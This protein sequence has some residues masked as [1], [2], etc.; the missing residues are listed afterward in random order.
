[1]TGC[2]PQHGMAV[3]EET[4]GSTASVLLSWS[5]LPMR[6]PS[7][8]AG[9]WRRHGFHFEEAIVTGCGWPLRVNVDQE[10]A[11]NPAVASVK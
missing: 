9:S 11:M 6:A 3:R 1:M 2:P 5:H 7:K 4:T 8:A 10:L